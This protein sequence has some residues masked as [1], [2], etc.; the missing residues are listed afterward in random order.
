MKFKH[1][2]YVS[3]GVEF[4]IQTKYMFPFVVPNSIVVFKLQVKN[5]AQLAL[6]SESGWLD[7]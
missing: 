6:P 7:D 3:E 4:Q 5:D 1:I 2:Y